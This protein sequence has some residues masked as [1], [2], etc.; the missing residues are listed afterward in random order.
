MAQPGAAEEI[1]RILANARK[2]TAG[3]PQ[4]IP[5]KELWRS[6]RQR[7]MNY[8]ALCGIAQ[9]GIAG[10]PA[11]LISFA[12]HA[13]IAGMTGTAVERVRAY[14]PGTEA[15]NA[16]PTLEAYL[17]LLESLF[18]P[19]SESRSLKLEFR[20]RKQAK[21]EDVSSFLSSKFAL[22][23]IAY[24][25]EQRD[26]ETLLTEVIK[27]LFSIVVKRRLQM[28]REVDTRERL[29]ERLFEIV[30][31]EREAY[32]CGFAESTSL[33]GLVAV[34]V[35]HL[36]RAGQAAHGQGQGGDEP[37]EV[38][39][40]REE[41]ARLH[42]QAHSNTGKGT[43]GGQGGQND[44]KPGEKRTCYNC[45]QPGHLRRQ[46]PKPPRG[47]GDGRRDKKRKKCVHC[48]KI[49][50][51]VEVC[52]QR[53]ADKATA[54]KSVKVIAGDDEVDDDDE[55]VGFLGNTRGV[56]WRH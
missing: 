19:P 4:F 15:A 12:K 32:Q 16:C 11:E 10:R 49:G 53:I 18:Q 51:T 45:R 20:N 42:A 14:L 24:P 3:I 33:D 17:G 27:G 54:K 44:P 50:H 28:A 52:R 7:L 6:Y 39:A 22:Y 34:A 41:I 40:M 37:M 26:H 35:P 21:D 29:R 23:D 5:E 9:M 30:S 56:Q 46:C 25:P 1:D 43:G 8:F 47:D 2:N 13:V 31:K 38:D 36:R 55:E 48:G